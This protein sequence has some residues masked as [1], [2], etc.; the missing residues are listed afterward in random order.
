AALLALPPR[1][2]LEDP[3]C[4]FR[5]VAVP[6]DLRLLLAFSGS[7][8]DS[9]QL[10]REVRAWATWA[11]ARWQ[12]HVHQISELCASARGSPYAAAARL[13]RLLGRLAAARPRGPRL[14]HLGAGALAEARP[15]DQRAVRLAARLALAGGRLRGAK[16][17]GARRARGRAADRAQR[18]R[19]D[20]RARL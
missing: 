13:Q 16:P 11:P 14:G 1:S 8:A 20:G 19:A 9:R 12:K 10:V 17:R 5:S 18:R 6:P 7:S 4:D 3:P 2:L 15:P